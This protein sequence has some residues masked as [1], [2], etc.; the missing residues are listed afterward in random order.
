M[1]ADPLTRLIAL[2]TAAVVLAAPVPA[3][4]AETEEPESSDPDEQ[5]PEERD[6]DD[7][8][9]GDDDERQVEVSVD[10]DGVEIRLQRESAASE[11][12]IEVSFEF[13]DAEFETKY[14]AESGDAET[15]M[16]LQA[17]LLRL[18]EYRDANN[19]SRY[20]PGEPILSAW[21]FSGSADEEDDDPE[22]SDGSVHWLAPT[23][24]DVTRDNQSGK[25]I[26][27]PATLG[28]GEFELVMWVFGDFV[29]LE[30]STLKPTSV[31]IDFHIRNYP[32]HANNTALAL[33]LQTESK[34][35]FEVERD[36]EEMEDDEQGVSASAQLGGAP[37][38]LVFTWK[39]SATVDGASKPVYTT[40][41]RTKSET[42]TEDGESETERKELFALSYARG[43][44]IV[45]DPESYVAIETAGKGS[46]IPGWTGAAALVAVGVAAL[47]FAHGRR[48]P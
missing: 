3:M 34:T 20:D 32:Y 33:F 45:H 8:D 22:P 28:S 19:N 13:D 48:R 41:L 31:K 9:E 44:D 40:S 5:E 10:G 25:Q 39:D 17:Q 12:K 30:N 47:G 15:E 29:N 42:E 7:K 18:A 37:V 11:D 23:V 26:R 14:E 2:M 46:G 6:E 38:S 16:K 43:M 1:F 21:A 4:A 35:E 36:H 27:A 24:S